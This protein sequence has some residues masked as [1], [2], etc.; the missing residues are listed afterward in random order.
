MKKRASSQRL[1]IKKQK[2]GQTSLYSK[3][4][5][6]PNK[7]DKNQKH[8]SLNKILTNPVT[9]FNINYKKIEKTNF[10]TKNKINKEKI[11][12]SNYKKKKVIKFVQS[13]KN[14]LIENK[15]TNVRNPSSEMTFIKNGFKRKKNFLNKKIFQNNMITPSHHHLRQKSDMNFISGK[16]KKKNLLK[17]LFYIP[18]KNKDFNRL[19]KK[20]YYNKKLSFKEKIKDKKDK[21][22]FS[23]L[24]ENKIH[25]KNKSKNHFSMK[26]FLKS[27]NFQ[28]KFQNNITKKVLPKKIAIKKLKEEKIKKIHLLK[29]LDLNILFQNEDYIYKFF[30][31]IFKKK[32][33]YDI[34]KNYIDFIQDNNIEPYLELIDKNLRNNYKNSFI[35]ENVTLM[36]CFYLLLNKNYQNE[37]IFLRKLIFSVYSNLYSFIFLVLDSFSKEY[38]FK[39]YVKNIEIIT[40]RNIKGFNVK[41]SKKIENN[42]SKILKYIKLQIKLF[43]P[44]IFN[45]ILKIIEFLDDFD[46][47]EGFT[48]LLNIFSKVYQNKGAITKDLKNMKKNKFLDVEAIIENSSEKSSTVLSDSSRNLPYTLVLDLDETLVHCKEENNE[49][50]VFFRP[51]V[52]FFLEKMSKYY[53]IMIFT[54]ALKEYADEVLDYLDPEKKIISKRFYRQHLNENSIK[55][56]TK[57]D[58]DLSKCIIIDNLPENFTNQQENG[59]FIKSW[60][61][62]DANDTALKDL[63]PILIEIV[64]TKSSDVREFLK[65]YKLKMIE[66]IKR[67]SLN[68]KDHFYN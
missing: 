63:M 21:K 49:G 24:E 52:D 5:H 12:K 66:K 62:N 44:T 32:D 36:I 40:N 27:K 6:D 47:R 51:Y 10:K 45:S 20:S 29:K 33:I 43:E 38:I 41:L 15:K 46:L 60:Y 28:K 58:R 56:L 34:F 11:K 67:G 19:Q 25:K 68:P 39:K 55:D 35:L 30:D 13:T 3:N 18:K 23:K 2:I 37:I 42:N 53:E 17:K 31:A 7:S 26:E 61:N 64:E 8:K 9:P 22:Y 14:L 1:D 54:A 16:Y 4:K 59:I 57:L 48:Y 65:N 50:K